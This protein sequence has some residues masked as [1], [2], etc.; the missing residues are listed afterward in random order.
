MGVDGVGVGGGSASDD[1][2]AAVLALTVAAPFF[3]MRY[4]VDKSVY[5]L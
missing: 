3:V 2:V 1:G 4:K 5:I